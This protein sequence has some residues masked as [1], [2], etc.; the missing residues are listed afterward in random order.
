M[1]NRL[2]RLNELLQREISL[3]LHTRFSA[4]AARITITGVR[5]TPDLHEAKV[6]F[7]VFGALP[8]P[9]EA[10]RWLG[11]TVPVLSQH[12]SKHVKMRFQ[13]KLQFIADDQPDRADRVLRLLDELESGREEGSR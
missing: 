11:S 13:P 3:V 6:Y 8:P 9:D 1:S 7:T 4:E 12:L 2:V 10:L 5:I